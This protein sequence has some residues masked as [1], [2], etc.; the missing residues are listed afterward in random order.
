LLLEKTEIIFSQHCYV[1][2]PFRVKGNVL[3]PL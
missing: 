2:Q 3:V 1:S